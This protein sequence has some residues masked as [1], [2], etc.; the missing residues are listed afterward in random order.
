MITGDNIAVARHIA[1]LL[2]IGD[3]IEDVRE[4]KGEASTST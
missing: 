4:L 2:D 1:G 3:R